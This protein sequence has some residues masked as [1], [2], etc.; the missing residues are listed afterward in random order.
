MNNLVS[1][2]K[3]VYNFVFIKHYWIF[4]LLIVCVSF[5]QILKMGVWKDDNAIFFKFDHIYEQAGFFGRGILGEGPY[6]FSI[7]PYYFIHLIFGNNSFVPYYALILFFYFAS[8]LSVEHFFST[9]FTKSTGKIAAFLFAAGY[10]ASEGFMWLSNAMLSNLAIISISLTI[11]FYHQYFKK[12][13]IYFYLLAVF[14]YWITVAFAPLRS[15]FFIAFILAYEILYFTVKKFPRTLLSS[16]FRSLP[17]ILI[18]NHFFLASS[19]SRTLLVKDYLFSLLKGEYFKTYSFFS[20]LSNLIVPDEYVSYIYGKIPRIEFILI[21][22]LFFYYF[23]LFAKNKKRIILSFSSLGITIVWY[24]IS[25]AI[26]NVPELSLPKVY[27]FTVFLGG[28]YL[29]NL[30]I[31]FFLVDDNLKKLYAL[32]FIWLMVSLSAYAAYEPTVLFN[33]IHRYLTNAFFVQVGIL[34]L[35]YYYFYR[36][37]DLFGKIVAVAILAWGMM[38]ILNSVHYQKN[39]VKERSTPVY[40]FY[41]QLKAYLPTINKGDVLYFDTAENARKYFSDAFSVSSMPETTAIAWRYGLDRYDFSLITDPVELNKVLFDK[42]F[43]IKKIHTFFY[44]KAGLVDTTELTKTM[45]LRGGSKTN[46]KAVK[47]ENKYRYK[48]ETNQTRGETSDVVFNLPQPIISI[49]PLKIS[50][51]IAANVAEVGELKPPYVQNMSMLV[52]PIALKNSLRQ[53]AF[54]CQK[55]TKLIT[56]GAKIDVSSEWKER[57]KSNLHDGDSTTIWQSDRIAWGQE[58]TFVQLDL[59]RV[60]SIDKFNWSINPSER[61][62]P[63]NYYLETSFDGKNWKKGEIFETLV[64]VGTGNTQTVDLRLIRTRFIRMH[65]LKTLN[66]DSPSI[67]EILVLPGSCTGLEVD[68]MKTFIDEPFGYLPDRESYFDTLRSISK[69]GKVKI[70]WKNDKSGNWQTISK[71]T[72]EIKYDGVYREYNFIIPPGGTKL[73]AL[74]LS[75]GNIPGMIRISE[76]VLEPVSF[77]DWVNYEKVN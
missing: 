42:T 15:H 52:N 44:E 22:I 36:R 51:K 3:R 7:T 40:N 46:L 12:R 38:N 25:K 76:I 55:E 62:T 30:I 63:L 60:I 69:S 29:Y 21:A 54:S 33:T 49:F 45:L 35:L 10:I 43:E 41:K 34:A 66:G 65:I 70:F 13:K 68:Q 56:D 17:F 64:K 14:I 75:G 77:A 16:L 32:L 72:I 59:G 11:S 67:S 20:S 23:A 74:K 6:R 53:K 4:L 71:N 27:F 39:I 19:D 2:I 5:G 18:F 24:F 47:L 1:I 58:D 31:N 28:I 9:L 50:F 8:T 57:V 48:Y 26:F 73:F 61:N 37:K